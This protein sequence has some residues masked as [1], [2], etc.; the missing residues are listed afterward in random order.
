MVRENSGVFI[1]LKNIIKHD[2]IQKERLSRLLII[3]RL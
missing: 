3:S 1:N 2:N